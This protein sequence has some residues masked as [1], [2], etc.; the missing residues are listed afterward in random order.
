[1]PPANEV[2]SVQLLSG[3]NFTGTPKLEFTLPTLQ[4]TN[5]IGGPKNFSNP[6]SSI[7]FNAATGDMLVAERSMNGD[8]NNKNGGFAAH[9]SRYLEYTLI[10]TTWTLQSPAKFGPGTLTSSGQPS[11]AGGAA[12]DSCGARVWGTADAMHLNAND[13]LY[14]IQGLPMSGGTVQNSLLVDLTD[15]TVNQDKNQ[16]GDL[17]I[18]C[19]TCD[20]GTTTPTDCCDKLTAVPHPQENVSLDYRTFTITNL[21]APVSPICSVDISMNPTPNPIWQGGDLYID[22]LLI[23]T[24]TRFISPYARIPNKPTASSI[25]A[26]NTVKFN[27]G[28]DYTIGWSGTVTFVVHHC[29]NS[30]CTLTYGPWSALPPS[31]VPGTQVFDANVSQEG[32]LYTLGLQ[33][34]QRDWKGVIKW[35]SFRVEGEKSQIF[36]ASAPPV[37]E[38]RGRA[39]AEA[40]VENS[41]LSQTSVL[42]T[43]AQPL[44]PGQASS[45]FN[46]VVRR[47][48]NAANTPLVIW[49]TYDAN[50][51]A[52]ETGTINGAAQR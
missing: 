22:G 41:G 43:F 37:R 39:S 32:K 2:W 36:A 9:A 20:V 13:Q 26:V 12:Y 5:P 7:S 50:G 6:V 46:L 16:M 14:G 51:N 10:G 4:S 11:S 30:T 29:D 31:T 3:G 21:K 52:L 15:S 40:F 8:R 28:V 38:S 42:Y 24:A 35:I 34:K 33:L 25:S 1:M 17:E 48:S 47:D 23:P 44:K 49:T 27:L 45:I 19:S 18:P